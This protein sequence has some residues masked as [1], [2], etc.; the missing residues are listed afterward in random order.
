MGGKRF[1]VSKLLFY[2]NI[3]RTYDEADRVLQEQGSRVEE[4][5]VRSSPRSLRLG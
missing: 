1:E 4:W 3:Y 5:R 2:T